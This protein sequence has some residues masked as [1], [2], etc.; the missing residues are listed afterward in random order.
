M[1]MFDFLSLDNGITRGFVGQLSS[2][3]AKEPSAAAVEESVAEKTSTQKPWPKDA[4]AERNA[5]PW[6]WIHQRSV[7]G[8]LQRTNERLLY[9]MPQLLLQRDCGC[10]ILLC[11]LLTKRRWINRYCLREQRVPHNL[12]FVFLCPRLLASQQY[13]F[14]WLLL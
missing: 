12:P 9:T 2:A 13:A 10:Y 6:S 11:P 1:I 4:P 8:S 5:Y 3:F 7:K 14:R